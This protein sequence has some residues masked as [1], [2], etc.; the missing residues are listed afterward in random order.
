MKSICLFLISGVLIL[1]ACKSANKTTVTESNNSS[2]PTAELLETYWKLTELNGKPIKTEENTKEVHII[3]K[4]ENNRLQGFAGCNSI[5][6][7]YELKEGNHI[8]FTKI[9]TTLM[10]CPNMETE[11][12][13][14]KVLETIDNYS[15]KGNSL[16]LNKAKMPLA[17]FEAVN[18]K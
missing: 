2:N 18:L 8:V 9:A 16:S 10:A 17:R 1:F 15:L 12:G 13:L 6:G 4:K 3:L 14:K 5:M 7:A 11:D